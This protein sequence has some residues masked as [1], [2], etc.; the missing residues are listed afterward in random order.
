MDAL[1]AN[2]TNES[3]HYI[4]K[5]CK[6][7]KNKRK[8]NAIIEHITSIAIKTVQPYLYTIL[9]ILFIMFCT[10]LLQFY[11]YL[12]AFIA[13]KGPLEMLTHQPS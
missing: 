13:N 12:K 9:G 8:L 4:Y 6:K 1:L 3:I 7:E 5:Q 10:N 2:V 11:Y